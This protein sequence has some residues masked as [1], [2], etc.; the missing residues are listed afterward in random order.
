V[1]SSVGSSLA[2]P[3]ILL[4]PA[5][6]VRLVCCWRAGRGRLAK[7]R[8]PQVSGSLDLSE[9]SSHCGRGG[10]PRLAASRLAYQ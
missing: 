5:P 7:R 3:L 10:N 4:E 8:M 6:K 2:L 9:V 1:T